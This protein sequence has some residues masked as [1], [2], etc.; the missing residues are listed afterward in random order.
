MESETIKTGN[1][2]IE[3]EGERL[4][5]T[6]IDPRHKNI[7]V[8]PSSGNSIIVKPESSGET[9][10]KTESKTICLRDKGKVCNQCHECDVD[11]L[12]PSY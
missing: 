11:I 6:L 5:I 2:Y 7:S 1:Y 8:I 9:Q 3:R 4:K 12:N 10:F